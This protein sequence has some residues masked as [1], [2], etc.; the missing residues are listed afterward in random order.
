M[1]PKETRQERVTRVCRELSSS[2]R[3]RARGRWKEVR[4]AERN[5]RDRHVWRF[6]AG[7][8][9]GDR[10]LHIEHRTLAQGT[11]APKRL[12]QQ[13]EQEGWLDRLQAGPDKSLLLSADGQLAAFSGR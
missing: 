11:D 7:P 1:D 12:M 10:F 13:L 5:E 4:T 9:A 3:R 6:Q 2:I 8:G